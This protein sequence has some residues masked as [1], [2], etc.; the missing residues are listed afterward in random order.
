MTMAHPPWRT[1]SFGALSCACALALGCVED[2]APARNAGTE[3]PGGDPA[4]APPAPF[5]EAVSSPPAPGMVWVAGCWHWDG[6]GYTWL[7]GH[8]DSPPPSP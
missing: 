1:I 8:W 2:A 4:Q 7:P 5:Q 3:S 6:S